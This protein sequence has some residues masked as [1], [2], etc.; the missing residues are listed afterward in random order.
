M[1]FVLLIFLVFID[2][3]FLLLGI[4]FLLSKLV[5]FLELV[6]IFLFLLFF[7]NGIGFNKVDLKRFEK[8]ILEIKILCK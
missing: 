6:K 3:V 8:L 5:E 2:V 7:I 4:F 1:I